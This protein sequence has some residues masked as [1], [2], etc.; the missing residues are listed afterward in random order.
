MASARTI[1]SLTEAWPDDAANFE[2]QAFAAKLADGR[3]ELSPPA[4]DRIEAEL[5]CELDR[6]T[7]SAQPAPRRS[8]RIVGALGSAARMAWPY[9]AAACVLVAAGVWMNDRQSPP[10]PVPTPG[11]SLITDQPA[12]WQPAAP[13]DPAVLPR[14]SPTGS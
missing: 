10:A 13:E 3:P 4:L 2:L 9:A 5:S 8:M 6:H 11:G 14:P 12:Q 1:S 7:E